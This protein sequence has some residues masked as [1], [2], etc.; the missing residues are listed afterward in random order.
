MDAVTPT[1]QNVPTVYY[2]SSDGEELTEKLKLICDGNED[3]LVVYTMDRFVPRLFKKRRFESVGKLETETSNL[4]SSCSQVLDSAEIKELNKKILEMHVRLS[5]VFTFTHPPRKEK[6]LLVLDIDHTLYDGKSGLFR[7]FLHELLTAA[8]K[9]YDIA[10]WSATKRETI[11]SKL[12]AMGVIGQDSYKITMIVNR[13][14][15][16]WIDYSLAGT[17]EKNVK[18]KPL[19][20]IW[21]YF[22]SY[23]HQNTI[24]IDDK[25]ENFKLNPQCGL[26]IDAFHPSSLEEAKK[27]TLL[28]QLKKYLNKIA[29]VQ[30]FTTLDHSA[31]R[32]YGV[33]V[34]TNLKI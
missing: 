22:R 10:I 23:S 3:H 21:N 13:C 34:T 11:L 18:V 15:M 24:M 9:K 29:Y 4:T 30:D 12:A 20:V 33:R 16:L 17:P 27:D 2:K 7:P 25:Q 5:R 26:C 28:I 14:A 32:N 31:W 19:C 1:P 8:Y 6:K